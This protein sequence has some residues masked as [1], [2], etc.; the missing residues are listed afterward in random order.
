MSTLLRAKH[1]HLFV[2][3]YGFPLV[4]Q[5]LLIAAIFNGIS[6]A[7]SRSSNLFFNLYFTVSPFITVIFMTILMGWIYSIGVGLQREIPDHLRR[8]TRFFKLTI[9]FP[10]IYFAAAFAFVFNRM[11]LTFLSSYVDGFAIILPLH[12]FAMFCMVYMLYYSA[13]TLKTA[14]LQRETSFT[15][16]AGEFFLIWFF[17][18]GIWFLQPKINKLVRPVS[19]DLD[20]EEF[21]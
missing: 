8:P 11:A 4:L 12:L 20:K 16:F 17:P 6:D 3:V 14:E 21:V 13:K 15:D 2:L 19:A 9:I 18:I 1:W 5:I 7:G 10:V